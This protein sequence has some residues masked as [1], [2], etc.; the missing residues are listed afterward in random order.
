M[1]FYGTYS[2]NSVNEGL[3]RRVYLTSFSGDDEVRDAVEQVKR[4]FNIDVEV[5]D[6]SGYVKQELPMTPPKWFDPADA[7]EAWSEDDY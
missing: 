4:A 3:E 5:S 1:Y 6:S 7:G 2:K